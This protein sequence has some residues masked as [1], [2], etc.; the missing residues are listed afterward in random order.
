LHIDSQAM[1]KRVKKVAS[2]QMES[3]IYE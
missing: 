1:Q 2:G 3:G